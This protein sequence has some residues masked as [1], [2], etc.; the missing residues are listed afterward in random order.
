MARHRCPNGTRKRVCDVGGKDVT[1]CVNACALRNSKKVSALRKLLNEKDDRIQKLKTQE[2]RFKAAK[3]AYKTLKR[4]NV[5]LNQTNT[6]NHRRLV[7]HEKELQSTKSTFQ[8]LQHDVAQLMKDYK[9][10]KVERDRAIEDKVFAQDMLDQCE[11]DLRV[12]DQAKNNV[13]TAKQQQAAGN[14]LRQMYGNQ[15][16]R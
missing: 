4:Q 13:L 1:D 11:K 14:K 15:R 5:G 10:V 16:K 8:R 9:D 7:E 6:R 12:C 2:H 3:K